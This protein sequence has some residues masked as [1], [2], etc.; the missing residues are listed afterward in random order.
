MY[1]FKLG[2]LESH[3]VESGV[4]DHWLARYLTCIFQALSEGFYRYQYCI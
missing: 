4:S 1:F 3:P 2:S